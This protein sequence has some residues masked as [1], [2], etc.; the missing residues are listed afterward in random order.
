MLVKVDDYIK[1]LPKI[2]IREENKAGFTSKYLYNPL[3][4]YQHEK[5]GGGSEFRRK[6]DNP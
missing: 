1:N 5:E 2:K 3:R 4:F 6:F